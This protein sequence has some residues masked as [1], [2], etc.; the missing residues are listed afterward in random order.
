MPIKYDM[1]AADYHAA[2][3]VSNSMLN[4]LHKSPFHCWAMHINPRRPVREQTA[5]MMLG[6]LAHTAILEPGAMDDRYVVRPDDIDARTKAGKEWIAAQ[7]RSIITLDQEGAAQKQRAAV[8]AVPELA[9]ILKRGRAESSVFWND[10]TTGLD[11]RC[12]PDWLTKASSGKAIV[13]DLK[14]TADASA[15][16]FGRSIWTYGYHRQAAHYTAGIEAQGIEVEAFVFAVVTNSYPFVAAAYV[17]D[18]DSLAQG[19]EEISELLDLYANCQ[20]S[21]SWPFATG[22]QIASLPKWAR[23]NLEIEVSYA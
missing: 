1:T 13:L 21:G 7:D 2:P 23:R 8:L 11:C 20:R 15:D 22:Y 6:T 16:A 5:P 18:E 19:Q 4:D 17:L 10:A 12:R 9:E 3:G 14:T